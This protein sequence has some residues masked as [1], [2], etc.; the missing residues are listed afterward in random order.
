VNLKST[1]AKARQVMNQGEKKAKNWARRPD[2]DKK[3]PELPS[4]GKWVLPSRG[5]GRRE[6]KTGPFKDSAK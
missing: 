5:H 6:S 2:S 3:S 4:K 1:K